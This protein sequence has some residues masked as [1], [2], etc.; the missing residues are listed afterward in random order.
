MLVNRRHARFTGSRSWYN[1]PVGEDVNKRSV[2]AYSTD[3]ATWTAPSVLF[4][5]FT[6]VSAVTGVIRRCV[7]ALRPC[8]VTT[9]CDR[10]L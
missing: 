2:Y 8:A 3:L 1:A 4:D 10:V 6:Q 9:C 5:T 7:G